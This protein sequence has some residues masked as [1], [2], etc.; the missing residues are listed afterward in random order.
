LPKRHS[1][2]GGRRG[3]HGCP[4]IG[5]ERTAQP[6]VFCCAPDSFGI[7]GP[8]ACMGWAFIRCVV[9]CCMLLAFCSIGFILS[10]RPITRRIIVFG[11]VQQ[12]RP[13]SGLTRRSRRSFPGRRPRWC[14]SSTV[15]VLHR[16]TLLNSGECPAF[17]LVLPNIKLLKFK[18]VRDK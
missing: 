17:P 5:R 13:P 11:L 7:P 2:S 4:Q 18:R 12:V 9:S 15:Q 8:R 10:P 6:A 1:Q 14:R 3:A 16:Y